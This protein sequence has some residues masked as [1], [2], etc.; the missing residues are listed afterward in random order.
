MKKMEYNI[1][2]GKVI[3]TRRCWMPERGQRKV[4]GQRI[5]GNTSEQKIK[6]NEREA[7][8]KLGRILNSNFGDG[9]LF[10]TMKYEPEYLPEDMEAARKSARKYLKKVR[11]KIPG[12]KYVMVTANYSPK[13]HRPARLHHHMVVPVESIDILSAL[14]T[15]GTFYVERVSN[16]GDLT[17]LAA[18]LVDNVH[19]LPAGQKKW[20]TSQGLDKPIYTEPKPV[21][22]LAN[23]QPIA[24]AVVC[25]WTNVANEDGMIEGTYMRQLMPARVKVRGGMVILPPRGKKKNR[26]LPDDIAKLALEDE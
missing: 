10:V 16:P 18:Y 6:A 13:R 1:I 17:T 24:G 12:M 7:V 3:E 26:K 15:V 14:W 2:S 21:E 9:F 25:E 4:R 11:E 19:D 5:A 23:V 22:D 8:K 20:T